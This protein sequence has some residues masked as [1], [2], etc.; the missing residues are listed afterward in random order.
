L[1]AQR[2]FNE[3]RGLDPDAATLMPAPGSPEWELLVANGY[4][5]RS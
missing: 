3:A 2:E 5:R 1:R 4:A